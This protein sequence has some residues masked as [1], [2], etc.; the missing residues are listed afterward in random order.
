MFLVIVKTPDEFK[1]NFG[2]IR[3]CVQDDLID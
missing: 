3:D 1:P 2:K